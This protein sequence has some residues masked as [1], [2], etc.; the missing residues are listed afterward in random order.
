MSENREVVY[1]LKMCHRKDGSIHHCSLKS[2]HQEQRRV[3]M[4]SLNR[5]FAIAEKQSWGKDAR[6][7]LKDEISSG[8]GL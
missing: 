2:Q 3:S 6:R 5:R 4:W 7:A 1:L 8:H